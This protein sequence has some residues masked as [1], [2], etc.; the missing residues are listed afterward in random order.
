MSGLVIN[1]ILAFSCYHAV[2][3]FIAKDRY[4]TDRY[5]VERRASHKIKEEDFLLNLV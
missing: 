4:L 1:T 3:V 5:H 2:A